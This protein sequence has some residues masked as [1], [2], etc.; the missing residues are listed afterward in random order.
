MKETWKTIN[1]VLNKSSK[2]TSIDSLQGSDSEIF[3]KKDISNTMNQFF[4]SVGKDLAS[5]IVPNPLPSGGHEININKG[6]FHA[7]NE[8]FD[9]RNRLSTVNLCMNKVAQ[10][11]I[12]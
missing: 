7:K 1:Q 12:D 5:K 11:I 8:N 2:S 9:V 3:H 4:Y 10:T 6:G